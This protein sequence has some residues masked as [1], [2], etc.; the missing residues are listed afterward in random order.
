MAQY[1]L[2]QYYLPGAG[3]QFSVNCNRANSNVV[4]GGHI[5]GIGDVWAGGSA[6]V[7][8]VIFK[9]DTNGKLNWAHQVNFVN[10][11]NGNEPYSIWP[12]TYGSVPTDMVI[13]GLDQN[14]NP[15]TFGQW[16]NFTKIDSTGNPVLSLDFTSETAFGDGAWSVGNVAKSTPGGNY[17]YMGTLSEAGGSPATF[18]GGYQV[19]GGTGGYTPSGDIF[20]AKINT[21]APND[22]VFTKTIGLAYNFF[23]IVS[24]D[25]TRNDA[26]EDFWYDKATNGL[27]I[28][29]LTVD[30]YSPGGGVWRVQMF[31]M[32]TDTL[33]NPQWAKTFYMGTGNPSTTTAWEA[34]HSI[35]QLNDG[36]GDFMVAGLAQ[37]NGGVLIVRIGTTGFVS[38]AKEYTIA[39]SSG[40]A[41]RTIT[42]LSNGNVLVGAWTQDPAGYGSTDLISMEVNPISGAVV[43]DMQIGTSGLDGTDNSAWYG[44]GVAELSSDSYLLLGNASLG[45]GGNYGLMVAK[46]SSGAS[47]GGLCSVKPTITVTDVTPGFGVNHLQERTWVPGNNY[48]TA[49]NNLVTRVGSAGGG[50]SLKT[51]VQVLTPTMSNISPSVTASGYGSAPTVSVG[52]SGSTTFC[53]GGNVTLNASGTATTFTWSP[54]TGLSATT[55][56]SVVASPPSTTTYTVTGT[57]AGACLPATAS[58]VVTIT[59]PPTIII[60]PSGATTFCNGGTVN[61]TASGAG[62]GGT[63][64][65]SPS[66]GLSATTG[67][68]VTANPASS[69]TY[70]VTGTTAGGCSN[71][72]TVA[73]TITP[74]PVVTASATPPAI[75]PGGSSTLNAGGAS[76]YTWAPNTGLSAT[77]GTSVTANPGTSQTYT[78]TGTSAA[79]C[80]A[81]Q[82]VSVTI[83]PIP[84][85][86]VSPANPTI[87]PGG[88]VTLTA[89]GATTYS[90][91]TGATT[92]SINVSPGS[93]TTYTVTGTSGGCPGAPTTVVVKV[94]GALAVTISPLNPAICKGDSVQL[95]AGGAATYTWKPAGGLSCVSC[96][97]PWANPSVATTYTVV[98]SSGACSDSATVVIKVNALPVI[99]A[100]PPAPTICPGGNVI[101]TGGGGVSY[102]W[103]P[104]GSLSSSTGTNVTATPGST[105]TYTVIGTNGNGCKD[106]AMATVTVSP[107]PVITINI[108]GIS[109]AVCASDTV[110]MIANGAGAGGTYTWSPAAGLNTSTGAYV[111]SQPAVTTT[112]TVTGTTAGGC[113]GTATQ[114]I[115]IYPTPTVTVVPVTPNICTGNSTVINASGGVSYTWSPATGLSATTGAS[116]T[117]TPTVTTT[118]TVTGKNASGCPDSAKAVITVTA[119]PV[120]SVAPASPAICAGGNVTLIASGGTTYTWS[121]GTGLS[122]TTGASVNATPTVTTTYTVTGTAGGCSDTQSVVITVSSSLNVTVTP[123]APILC[124]GG[125]VSLSA[126]GAASFTWTPATGLSCATCPNPIA[127]PTVTTTYK[128]VGSSGSC[129]D[130]ANVTITVDSMPTINVN[131]GQ[132]SICAGNSTTL[133][134]TGATSYTWNPGTGLSATTGA[135]VTATPGTTLT[136]TVYGSNAGGCSDSAMITITVNTTPT[137]TISSSGSDSICQGQSITLT[138]NGVA[139]SY[140]WSNG[141]TTSSITVSPSGTTVYS[142]VDSNGVCAGAASQ[143]VFVYPPFVMTMR[144]DSICIGN[145]AAVTVN[146]SGGKP[147][148]VYS[149]NGTIGTTS[150]S[151]TPAG[152]TYY[153]CTVTDGCGDVNKDSAMVYTFPTPKASFVP[154][155]DTIQAGQYVSFVNKSTGTTNYYWTFGN[156][157][158]STDPNPYYQYVSPGSYIVTLTASNGGCKDSVSDTVYV[159]QT[160]FIP[161]VFTPNNDGVNDVFHVTMGGMK[162]YYIEIFNRW[163]ERL[164]MA[165]SANI[166][167]DGR[168]SA[169]IDESDGIYYYIIKATDYTAKEYNFQGYLQLIRNQIIS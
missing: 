18:D 78:V 142:V 23:N 15:V 86:T 115:T 148:Y 146:A 112:Y 121:P 57:A 151:V 128:V 77:I 51:V 29:G 72:Q 63:Y 107:P 60:T 8:Y 159:L 13:G 97:N 27:Y 61:L 166:D 80:T 118:Y 169:G 156:E 140:L 20:I 99:T 64:T 104:A 165:N 38:Y 24:A 4:N 143:S 65:W 114:V 11:G 87:C 155:P 54:A 119:N 32:K 133:T 93:T 117:A 76:T 10:P 22:T 150:I 44:P 125:S 2:D 73:I 149:W 139:G 124:T 16:G 88:N 144:G 108:T 17:Y 163:G 56:A 161:N 136:Y 138:A 152:S 126:N 42:T 67:A 41:A 132:P 129:A 3:S 26:P 5:Y 46:F 50:Y 68:T 95:L 98:G 102:T 69:Q 53:A 120:V 70:T 25:S 14:A 6:P 82:T 74:P 154:T 28:T 92:S 164:F 101:L 85:V 168:S 153:E 71:T 52:A 37:D 137:V 91:N 113:I 66:T 100:N 145:N 94:S 106:S 147:G 55:G 90:W 34:G 58:I 116:V 103:S 75:C 12:D 31:I 19:G 131:A 157:G 21:G 30:Q 122:A 59:P 135:T 160:I 111:I 162:T 127:T 96:S 109:P 134:A 83:K 158:T 84:T 39:G 123:S 49:P 62:G 141:A 167:W 33:G 47:N 1:Y 35:T 9:T 7:D 43:N 130:S 40:F 79:G 89:S 45:A 81:T 105:T 110:G 36:S 48:T